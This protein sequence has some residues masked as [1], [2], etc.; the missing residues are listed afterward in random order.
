MLEAIHLLRCGRPLTYNVIAAAT[1]AF[2]LRGLYRLRS[3]RQGRTSP[4]VVAA[5]SPCNHL[6]SFDPW[7]LGMPLWPK[8]FLCFMAKSELYWFPLKQRSS[9]ARAHFRCA[10]DSTTRWRW[11]TATVLAREGQHRHDVPGGHAAAEG[12]E[13]SRHEA[14]PRSGR[15]AHRARSRSAARS[16]R[17]WKGTDGLRLIDKLRR[18]ATARR[19][20]SRICAAGR[21][22]RSGAGG[23]GAADGVASKSR[24][25]ALSCLCSRSTATLSRTA[26]IR[27]C[28]KNDPRL[29]TPSSASRTCSR[30]S[31]RPSSPTRCW[32]AG[33]RSTVPTYRHRCSAYQ[34]GASSNRSSSSSSAA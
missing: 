22:A 9:T 4:R 34:A 29:T 3:H 8:T 18:R 14:R 31:G 33:T 6:S 12:A 24:G 32:S 20:T 16:R 11:D 19:S 25:V 15:S 1:L 23:Y 21:I 28:P 2:L 10:A 13:S 7:L 26:P 17:V 30:G 27:R 5:S